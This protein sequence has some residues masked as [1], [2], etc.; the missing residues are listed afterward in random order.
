MPPETVDADET[1]AGEGA[2]GRGTGAGTTVTGVKL[3]GPEVFGD[4]SAVGADGSADDDAGTSDF[5]GTSR[6]RRRQTKKLA[7]G[8]F[9][10]KQNAWMLKPLDA[11]NSNTQRQ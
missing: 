1:G 9:S 4:D 10:C 5:V 7:Y 11:C 3:I 8:I 2:G 6:K